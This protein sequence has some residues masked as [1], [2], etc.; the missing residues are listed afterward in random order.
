LTVKSHLAPQFVMAHNV[1]SMA[2][3]DAAFALAWRSRYEPGERPRATDRVAVWGTRLLLP[4]GGLAVLAGTAATASGPHAGGAGTGDTIKR[5]DFA[6]ADT[7][8]WAIG[9]HAVIAALFGVFAIALWV[10]LRRRTADPMLRRAVTILIGL[11]ALQGIVGA[12]QYSLELPSELVWVHVMIATL[13]WVAVLWATASAGFL[14]AKS[15]E[16]QAAQASEPRAP[17]L[18]KV[19]H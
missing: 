8:Q 6:G 16:R 10:V 4:I 2:V 1:L 12:T 3:I 19:A 9:Q 11:L 18:D 13:T 15:T 14:V 7:L 17:R 5:L